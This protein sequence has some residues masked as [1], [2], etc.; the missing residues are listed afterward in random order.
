MN[1][2]ERRAAAS[3]G[4]DGHPPKYVETCQDMA[5]L[6][7]RFVADGG[8]PS[9]ALPPADVYAIAPLDAVRDKVALNAEA[10]ACVDV[11]CGIGVEIGGKGAQPTLAMLRAV[12]EVV[13]LA[14]EERPVE[15]FGQFTVSGPAASN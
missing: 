1:R 2:R 8:K 10:R 14:H 15:H 4:L 7:R 5:H 11:F 13:G 6:L 12:L 9:F 3:L